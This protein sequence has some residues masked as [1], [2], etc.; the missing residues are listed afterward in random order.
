[1]PNA[2]L[3]I[4]CHLCTRS[5]QAVPILSF[6]GRVGSSISLKF[7][8]KASETH[9]GKRAER[10]CRPVERGGSPSLFATV[11]YLHESLAFYRW[12]N[13]TPKARSWEWELH[14]QVS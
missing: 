10:G 14:R 13:D 6:E 12:V 8:V 3:G 5:L 7:M 11:R 4:T 9:R 2:L 1:M